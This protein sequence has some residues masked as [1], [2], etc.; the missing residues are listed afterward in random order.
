MKRNH[1]TLRAA[2]LTCLFL[3]GFWPS[4]SQAGLDTITGLTVELND[5][6]I[7]VSANLVGGFDPATEEDIRNG[8]LKDLNYFI[9]LKRRHDLWFFDEN[10]LSTTIKYTV[11]YNLLTK[12]YLIT[13]QVG[14]RKEQLVAEDFASMKRLISTTGH[15]RIGSIDLLNRQGTYYISVKAEMRATQVPLYL[16]YF[17][18]F[19]PFLEM[20]TPWTDSGPF[21][22]E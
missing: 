16:D 7:Q 20:E 6:V 13:R 12:H 22:R 1:L 2:L 8:I 10:V 17:L 21:Y 14:P 19:I 11:K 5:Q 15:V 3:T 4:S 9:Y 18:F